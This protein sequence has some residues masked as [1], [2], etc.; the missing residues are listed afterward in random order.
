M[1]V[2]P[3]LT[4]VWLTLIDNFR[5]LQ[6]VC[7]CM[8]VSW[9]KTHHYFYAFMRSVLNIFGSLWNWNTEEELLCDQQTLGK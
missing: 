3:Q 8:C 1:S 4:N 9:V 7:V 6:C 2:I 5:F